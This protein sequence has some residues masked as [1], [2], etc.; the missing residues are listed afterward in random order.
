MKQI[1]N[2]LMLILSVSV[3]GYLV[4]QLHL[5]QIEKDKKKQELINIA[6]DL[7]K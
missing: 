5:H 3:M 6:L 7:I 2:W 4:Y 1:R